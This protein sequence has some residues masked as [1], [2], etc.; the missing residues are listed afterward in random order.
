[1]VRIPAW[2]QTATR[3]RVSAPAALLDDYDVATPGTLTITWDAF[4]SRVKA[5]Y[6]RS[7]PAAGLNLGLTRWIDLSFSSSLAKSRFERFGTTATG[8]SYV[9]AK[10][11]VLGEGRRRPGVAFQPVLE[12]L[13]R[14]SL[15]NNVLAPDKVNAVL[16]G[17]VGKSFKYLRIYNHSGYF[18]R[19][20]FF[21]SAQM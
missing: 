15:A 1:M 21:S 10:V 16:S 14:A 8:D 5:G 3:Q 4:Y 17:M 12:V 11:R 9:A 13:G 7:F 20:I 19:G 6:D 2:A 18:T